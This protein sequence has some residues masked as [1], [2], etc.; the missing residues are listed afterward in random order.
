MVSQRRRRPA[1]SRRCR[2]PPGRRRRRARR[3]S[4]PSSSPRCVGLAHLLGQL[5]QLLDDLRGL[6]G[7]VLVARGAPA[8]ASR[9]TSAPA[10]RSG[11]TRVLISS[12]EQLPQQLDGQVPLRQ[13]AHLGQELVGQDR[14]VRLLQPG[15]GEDVDDLVGRRPPARRSAGWRGR[16]PRR[17]A[18]RPASVFASAART[19]W[20]KPTSSRIAQRL[21][22]RARPGRTPATARSRPSG[23]APCRPPARGCAPAPP[24]GARAAR[25]ACR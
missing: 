22:V 11:A 21:V 20:K 3:R 10:R 1:P 14:D 13:A 24:A 4:G 18:A 6:D 16:G 19:A 25:C 7:P 9:R 5:D 23:A 15:R 2:W 12:V 17:S 8:P